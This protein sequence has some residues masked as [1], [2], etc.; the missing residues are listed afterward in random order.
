VVRFE[1]MELGNG[2]D[3]L[4]EVE[5]RKPAPGTRPV[6]RGP[7]RGVKATL[8]EALD[9][10]HNI[11]E[12]VDAKTRALAVRPDEVTLELGVTMTAEAG[13][14]IARAS[15]E[16]NLNLTLRWSDSARGQR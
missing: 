7:G 6:S 15:T 16:A 2:T 9:D 12:V 10:L 3:V 11:V 1:K 5:E 13:V 14:V 4:V 8:G